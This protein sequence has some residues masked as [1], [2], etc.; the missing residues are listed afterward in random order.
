MLVFNHL[1]H[2]AGI[3]SGHTATIFDTEGKERRCG[4][5]LECL[6]DAFEAYRDSYTRDAFIDT[7]LTPETLRQRLVTM[8]VFVAVN[9]A[10][11][12][13]GTVA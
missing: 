11:E 5:I 10:R 3:Y 7:V 13:V 8:C 2:E 12:I 9:Q 6:Q 4:G 1:I